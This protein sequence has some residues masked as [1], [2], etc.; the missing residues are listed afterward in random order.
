MVKVAIIIVNWKQ[1]KLTIDTVNSFLKLKKSSFY[2]FH[3]FVIDNNSPD[4][5]AA[6]LKN[7][8]DNTGN[9]TL[10]K[11]EINQGY[12]GGNNFGI[13]AA[14]KQNFDLILCANNDIIT[15]P[16]FLEILV[17]E[18]ESNPKLAIAAPKIYFAPGH[19]YHY[20]RYKAK[21]RGKVI[22]S[23]G[24]KFDWN[25]VYGSNIGIDQVDTGQFDTPKT[26]IDFLSGCCIL[27]RSSTIKKYGDFDEKY[28]MY[29]EDV[30]LCQRFLKAGYTIKYVPSAIIWHINSGSSSPASSIQDYFITRN[31][32]LFGGKYAKI[33]TKIALLKEAIIILINSKNYWQK[34]GIID[35]FIQ[36]WGIGSWH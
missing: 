30:E 25:N 16:A 29:L 20:D 15:D 17:K 10:L 35:F 1:A 9:I 3:I 6:V 4:N 34:R 11:T 21:D 26:D 8:F 33:R 12:V 19:E 23:A 24:G 13:R 2:K 27:I 14:L 7:K 36:K 18:I 5:S 28:F 22:W 31:R 32:L